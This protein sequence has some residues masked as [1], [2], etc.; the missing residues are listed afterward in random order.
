LISKIT[1]C[2]IS[3]LLALVQHLTT[4]TSQSSPTQNVLPFM[5]VSLPLSRSVVLLL[6]ARVHVMWFFHLDILQKFTSY[7][8][9]H[10]TCCHQPDRLYSNQLSLFYASCAKC[11]TIHC[12]HMHGPKSVCNVIHFSFLDH[13]H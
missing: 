7:F 8:P 1:T 2:Y 13:F 9:P 3:Q 12:K 5:A 11:I 4:W 6:A 10:K